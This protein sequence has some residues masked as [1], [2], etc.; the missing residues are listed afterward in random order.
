MLRIPVKHGN[1][2]KAL[3]AYKWKFKRTKVKEQLNER[4]QHKKKSVKRREVLNKAKHN[5]RKNRE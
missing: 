1:I 5:E 2:E 4:K 3:K